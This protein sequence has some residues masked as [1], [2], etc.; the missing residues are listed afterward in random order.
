M[1]VLACLTTCPDTA[2]AERIAET[3]VGEGLAACVN[4]VP[5]VI[6]IYRWQ[7][8]VERSAEVLLVVK[9]TEGGF[10]ALRERLIALHPY[11]LP[12]LIA[13]PVNLGLAAYLEWVREQIARP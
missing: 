7:G 13:V 6:S 3:L 10:A 9:T 1:T 2:T 8:V 5:G 4:L 11:E 12:E